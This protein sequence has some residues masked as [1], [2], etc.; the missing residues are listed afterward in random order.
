MLPA[1]P[2]HVTEFLERL[3][4][5]LDPGS[6]T[7]IPALLNRTVLES[8]K[9]F[10]P[11]LLV[12]MADLFRLPPRDVAPYA[13]VAELLHGATLAHDDVIDASTLRRNRATLNAMTSNSRAVL[14]G[15]FLLAR[16]IIELSELGTPDLTRDISQ[17]LEELVSGEWL[18][19]DARGRV[20]IT[21]QHLEAVAIRKTASLMRWCCTVPPRLAGAGPRVRDACDDFGRLFGLAFQMADDLLDFEPGG[22]KPYAQDLRDGLVNF[23][24]W[25]LLDAFPE[26]REGVAARLLS[27]DAPGPLPW[28]EAHLDEARRR[29]K[30]AIREKL[31][32]A[33]AALDRLAEAIPSASPEAHA[34]LHG[35]IAALE[36][37]IV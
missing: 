1:L 33:G 32:E 7:P 35:L 17:T 34:A 37:R 24:T 16:V 27:P 36:L 13:R 11:A 8:G 3:D 12:L 21:R 15:D 5:R 19:M 23:V 20:D 14:A 6:P 30:A 31:A 2:H 10:R 25:S 4:F 26:L 18:Q 28:T 9:R 22:E 29:V